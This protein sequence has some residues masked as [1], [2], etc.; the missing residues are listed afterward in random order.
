M[1]DETKLNKLIQKRFRLLD[2]GQNDEN[3]NEQIRQLQKKLRDE[4]T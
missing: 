4:N 1:K 3:L 2:F